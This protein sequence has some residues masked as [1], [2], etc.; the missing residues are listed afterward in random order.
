MGQLAS[1][2]ISIKQ[3]AHASYAAITQSALLA[4]EAALSAVAAVCE[5]AT[6]V[7]AIPSGLLVSRVGAPSVPRL[8]W[9]AV[10]SCIAAPIHVLRFLYLSAAA[11]V[12]GVLAVPSAIMLVLALPV[13]GVGAAAKCALSLPA[14]LGQAFVA[15][16][17]DFCIFCAA[18]LLVAMLGIGSFYSV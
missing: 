11:A 4:Q 9:K 16:P 10:A 5:A 8:A 13:Q 7:A 3:A 2:M 6:S 17:V 1:A 15:G 12:A 18:V 14:A